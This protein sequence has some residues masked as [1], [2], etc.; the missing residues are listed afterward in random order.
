MSLLN[1][2]GVAQFFGAIW[3]FV[4]PQKLRHRWHMYVKWT[5]GRRQV[6][7]AKTLHNTI[8]NRQAGKLTEK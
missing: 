6:H 5:L 2:L 4:I 8:R 1:K 3:R 7:T